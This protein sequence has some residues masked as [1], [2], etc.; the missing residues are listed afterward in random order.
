MKRTRPSCAW[1]DKGENER[2]FADYNKAIGSYEAKVL[3]GARKFT[4]MGV[5]GGR[6]LEAPE[7]VEKGLRE[8]SQG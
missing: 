2:A 8:I 7:Q 3:P 4:D 5:G 6:A 1:A